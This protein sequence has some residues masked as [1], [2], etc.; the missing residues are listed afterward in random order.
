MSTERNDQKTEPQPLE[1]RDLD[2]VQGGGM[3]GKLGKLVGGIGK[4]V[5][6]GPGRGSS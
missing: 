6:N 4:L 3:I 5:G 1:E 2:H